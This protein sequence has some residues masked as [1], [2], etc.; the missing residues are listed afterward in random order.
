VVDEK[1]AGYLSE[2]GPKLRARL[3]DGPALLRPLGNTIYVMPP[4]CIDEADLATVRDVIA[5][6]VTSLA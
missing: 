2:V 1:G 4:Y 3:R 5:E 6:A